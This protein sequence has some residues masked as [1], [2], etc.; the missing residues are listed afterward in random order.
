MA[1]AVSPAAPGSLPAG[2]GR[3]RRVVLVVAMLAVIAA[4]RTP[5]SAENLNSGLHLPQAICGTAFE[6]DR[7]GQWL[8]ALAPCQLQELKPSYTWF[9]AGVHSGN[10]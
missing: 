10:A 9:S 6:R 1:V 4:R 2:P 3:V 5:K 8:R 7:P